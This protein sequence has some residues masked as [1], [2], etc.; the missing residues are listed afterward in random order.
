MTC[1]EDCPCKDSQKLL[2]AGLK[3]NKILEE[4]NEIVLKYKIEPI[5]VHY[6]SDE[7]CTHTF[8]FGMVIPPG[9]WA[10]IN[11]PICGARRKVFGSGAICVDFTT[12]VTQPWVVFQ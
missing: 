10:Y 3:M 12:T 8:A 7:G 6:P 1:S 2:E 11:C 5:P 4:F 9:Q